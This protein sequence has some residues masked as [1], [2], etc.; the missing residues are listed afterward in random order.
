MTD[1]LRQAERCD[2]LLGDHLA[3]AVQAFGSAAL[4]VIDLPPLESP[5]HLARPQLRAAAAL[6]WCAQV[7]SSGL[8][9]FADALAEA[10]W[11]GRAPLVVGPAG[12]R[13][14]RYHRDRD[15]RFA[16]DERRAIYERLFGEDA[17]FPARW[18]RLI[19]ELGELGRAPL[20]RGTGDLVARA[21]AIAAELARELSDRAVGITGFAGREIVAH[22]RGALELL[23]DPDLARALGGGGP[24]QLVRRHAPWLLGHPLEPRP[25]LDRAE[26]GLT[27]LEWLAARA[28][29]LEG[30]ALL[31]GRDDPVVRA[32][33][34]W[35]AARGA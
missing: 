31:I 32:A 20:D 4:G 28:D 22:V 6:F 17:G 11:T 24:W 33:A 12:E 29:A 7:E 23:R 10:A 35:Q 13:L 15:E 1:L 21:Q 16:A 2:R 8:L 25:A 3:A 26:A 27:I 18:E 19:G 9:A 34:R 14:A 30:G 5:G